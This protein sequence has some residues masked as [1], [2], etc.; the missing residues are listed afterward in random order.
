MIIRELENNQTAENLR[1][2]LIFPEAF[3]AASSGWVDNRC[4]FVDSIN[5]GW[6]IFKPVERGSHV[7]GI[8]CICNQ[9]DIS[10]KHTSSRV[11][12]LQPQRC[13]FISFQSR[14]I[15]IYLQHPLLTWCAD[16]PWYHLKPSFKCFL[17][18][19]CQWYILL[20]FVRKASVQFCY[21]SHRHI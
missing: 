16:T 15:Y 3:Q 8:C 21:S 18:P 11:F 14:F 12:L 10:P 17:S 1:M 5:Q 2:H 7:L 20:H 4:P 6:A 9:T 13:I 19:N